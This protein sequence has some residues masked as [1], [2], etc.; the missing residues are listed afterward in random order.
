MPEKTL[1]CYVTA[2]NPLGITRAHD[3]TESRGIS[4][5]N[6][7]DYFSGK[8]IVLPNSRNFH[9]YNRLLLIGKGGQVNEV[10]FLALD[11]RKEGQHY[12]P[13]L[14]KCALEEQITSTSATLREVLD[15]ASEVD[16]TLIL[17]HGEV[18]TQ[19]PELAKL[20]EKRGFTEIR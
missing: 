15:S 7:S 19:Y 10:E 14:H 20:L 6:L 17:L 2:H 18:N 3:G 8:G 5:S 11:N 9:D 16:L 12:S 1:E 4:H 13:V